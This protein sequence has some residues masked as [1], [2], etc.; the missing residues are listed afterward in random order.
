MSTA[1]DAN[2][3]PQEVES[4]RGRARSILSIVLLIASLLVLL[5]PV[6][7]TYYQNQKQADIA[8]AYRNSTIQGKDFSELIEA[9]HAYNAESAGAPILDPWLARVAKN[10][11]PYQDYL[12]QLNVT[13]N[14]KDPMGVIAIPSI[15]VKLPVYHGTEPDVLERGIGHLYGSSLPVGGEGMHSV[16]TAHTGLAHATL[17]DDLDEVVT[18]DRIYLNVAGQQMTYEVDK[19]ETVLPTEISSL[20]PVP[21]KDLLTLITCTPYGINSHRLLVHAHRVPNDDAAARDAFNGGSSIQ[22]WML[23][24]LALIVLI[25]IAYFA[26]RRMNAHH[27]PRHRSTRSAA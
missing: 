23:L 11:R 15:K 26:R 14:P 3:S 10:N 9:A 19:I 4:T 13:G 2:S 16:L 12:E 22:W 17:F 27:A 8:D 6:V 25:V 24:V 20:Q 18:G 5:Y 7:T 1:S 21:G